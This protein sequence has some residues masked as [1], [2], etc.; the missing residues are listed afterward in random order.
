MGS[1]Q[2]DVSRML[3]GFLRLELSRVGL[4]GFRVSWLWPRGLG[5]LGT[6][7][8]GALGIQGLVGFG[9]L[10][11]FVSGFEPSD[12]ECLSINEAVS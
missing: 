9:G 10:R 11:F 7:G 12:S 1:Y 2:D 6:V 8:F 5:I 3:R 4:R